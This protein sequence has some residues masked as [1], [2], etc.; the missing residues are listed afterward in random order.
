MVRPDGGYDQTLDHM[1]TSWED[2][3]ESPVISLDPYVLGRL[4]DVILRPVWN[5]AA[6][7]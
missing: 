3:G 4:V 7:D 2:G 6:N 1:S 5:A